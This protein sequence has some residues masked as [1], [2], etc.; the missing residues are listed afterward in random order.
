MAFQRLYDLVF[1]DDSDEEQ[2]VVQRPRWIKEREDYFH[3]LDNED[4][5]IRFRLSKE[6]ALQILESIEDRIEFA[7]DKLVS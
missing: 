7:N 6:A 3:N 4:F 1:E 2:F 5:E